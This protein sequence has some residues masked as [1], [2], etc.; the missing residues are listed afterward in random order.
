MNA[1]LNA[2]ILDYLKSA[3]L[4]KVAKAMEKEANCSSKNTVNLV[5]VFDA[6]QK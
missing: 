2:S 3:G 6:A 4:A 1:D 5:T